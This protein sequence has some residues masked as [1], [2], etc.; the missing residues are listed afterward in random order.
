MDNK[1]LKTPTTGG[2]R[3]PLADN[4]PLHTPL[5]IQIFPVYAC[6]FKCGY[7]IYAIDKSK[8]GYISDRVFMEMDLYKKS[9][10]GMKQF[11]KKVKMLRFAAI[12][13]PLLH[14]NIADMIDYAKNADI[15]DNI[16]IVTNGSLLTEK[17]SD[18]LINAGL[19]KLRISLEG[20]SNEDYKK[21]SSV[22]IDFNRLVQNIAY[23]YK[24]KKQ[25]KI[26]IKIIDYMLKNDEYKNKFYDTFYPICDEI[27]I[28]H[29]T[30]T[31][32]DID[33]SKMSDE[34]LDKP[35]NEEKMIDTNICS[36]PFYLMQINPDGK[37]VPCC[38]MTYPEILGDVNINSVKEIW[39]GKKFNCFRL[40]QL[41]GTKSTCDVCK[42]CKTYL[43]GMHREDLLDN[44]KVEL[45]GKYKL[46]K[47]DGE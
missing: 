11:D 42:E 21:N 39:N 29:L 20:L 43:Y 12:G 15:A 3:I 33:Y 32:A 24:N 16:D 27:A 37:V 1:I 34:K 25:S 18:D 36:E 4:L 17:L 46:E 6:N 41:N 5:L 35:Q 40:R 23:F 10:D 9:I 47:E 22:N 26:Y 14:K 45:I 2:E 38:N 44:N 31:I 8:H 7:C 13:E 28:E 30:P 19:S